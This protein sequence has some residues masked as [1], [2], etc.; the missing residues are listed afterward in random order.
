MD[1]I[2]FD[3]AMRHPIS[4]TVAIVAEVRPAGLFCLE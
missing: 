1:N 3:F 4:H 2:D